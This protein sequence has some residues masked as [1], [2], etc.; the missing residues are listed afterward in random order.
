[1]RNREK[2]IELVVNLAQIQMRGDV[3]AGVIPGSVPSFEGL[4]S[5]VDA[6]EYGAAACSFSGPDDVAEVLAPAQEKLDQWIKEG[7]L[8]RWAA[9]T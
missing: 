1:M 7:G 6:N 4:H 3:D 8:R 9:R 5:Y 2:E